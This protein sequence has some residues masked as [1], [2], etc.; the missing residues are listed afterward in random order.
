MAVQTA[1]VGRTPVVCQSATRPAVHTSACARRRDGNSTR[2]AGLS[3]INPSR[4]APFNAARNV[5]RMCANVVGVCGCPYRLCSRPTA[6]KNAVNCRTVNSPNR[7]LPRCGIRNRSMYWVCDS[8]VVGR[9][10]TR[11]DSQYRSH[12]PS[13][14]DRLVC[15]SRDRPSTP[16]RARRAA[17]SVG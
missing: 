7:M 10:L 2:R 3:R 1:T 6:A 8:R 16:S 14:Q 4:I 12:R 13:V 9:M 5:V 11:V 17:A 15:S